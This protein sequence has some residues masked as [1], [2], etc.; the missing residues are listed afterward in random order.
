MSSIRPIEIKLVDQLFERPEDRGYVLDFSNS[1]FSS[2][3]AQE[4]K[5]D[6]YHDRFSGCGTSKMNRLRCYLMVVDDAK[7]AEALRAL[8][9]YRETLAAAF[10][11]DVP[12]GERRLN[13]LIKRLGGKPIT[14]AATE[15][16]PEA[17]KPPVDDAKREQLRNELIRLTALAPQARGLAFEKFLKDLFTAYGMEAGGSINIRGEQIDGSFRLDGQT[18]LFEAKWQN[19]KTGAP[20]LHIFEGKLGQKAVWTR[21]LFISQSGFTEQGLDAF[22]RGKRLICMDGLDLWEA[23]SGPLALPEVID[24]KARRASHTGEIFVRVRD[25]M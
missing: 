5:A 23:L 24:L 10:R 21:G 12:N 9:E 17:A 16:P 1:T 18:Y 4:L 22:G 13:E 19:E 2:F 15:P 11:A 3:F 25:L 8:W 14:S 7:A 20:D 6:I